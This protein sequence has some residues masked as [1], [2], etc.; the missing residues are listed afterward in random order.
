MPFLIEVSSPS[1][2]SGLPQTAESQTFLQA[3]ARHRHIL[4]PSRI[5]T[6]ETLFFLQVSF[7]LC[8]FLVLVSP[9]AP[10]N[11]NGHLYTEPLPH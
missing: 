6:S 4:E 8:V 10:L 9:T 5:F 2:L 7:P 3:H 11:D 1:T